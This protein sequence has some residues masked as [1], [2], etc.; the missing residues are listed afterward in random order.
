MWQF[1]GEAEQTIGRSP[2]NRSVCFLFPDICHLRQ[3]NV[4]E[5]R[6]SAEPS[7]FLHFGGLEL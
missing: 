1:Q 2:D 5:L 7:R 6:L 4:L 3:I